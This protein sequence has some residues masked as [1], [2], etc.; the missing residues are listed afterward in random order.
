MLRLIPRAPM[1]LAYRIA[2]RLRLMYWRLRK[3]TVHGCSV[4]A[5]NRAGELLLVRP[6]YGGSQWQFPGGGMGRD[7]DPLAAARREFAEETGLVLQAARS[8]GPQRRKFH[9]ATNIVH[10][11]IGEAE[12]APQ[13]DGREIV[14]AGW[15]GRAALPDDRKASVGDGIRIARI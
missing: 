1:R 7:E 3:P 13:G 12:G 15:F 10:F 14:E 5:R 6:S 11:V 2:H 4:I 8:L 9:G